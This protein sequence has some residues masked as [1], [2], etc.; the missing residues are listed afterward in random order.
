MNEV[1]RIAAEVRA[2]ERVVSIDL[3]VGD[4]VVAVLGPNGA[5]KTTL[6]RA[7]AGLAPVDVGTI[8]LDGTVV[9]NAT[10]FVPPE[11]RSVGMMF[12]DGRLFPFLD[13]R[14]NVAFALRSRGVAKREAR[15][16]AQV[17]LDQLG[18]AGRASARPAT[19]S[20]GEAQRVA[21]ARALVGQPRVLL[22]DEPLAALDAAARVAVRRDL[23]THL[24][25]APG[26]RILVTHDPVD[27]AAL[28]D[29]V[30]VLEGGRIVQEGSLAQVALHPRSDYAADL[31]GVNF[32]RGV[33]RNGTVTLDGGGSV[34]VADRSASGPV[35]VTVHPRSVALHG[36]DPGGSSRNRWAV[37]VEGIEDLGDRVRVRLAGP[38]DLVAEVTR[39]GADDLGLAPG[40]A[41]VATVKATEPAVTPA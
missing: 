22:L 17:W 32:L 25:A 3:S 6:L 20:G 23:R 10:T 24:A 26:A 9:D 38:P 27:A 31:A 28:A 35:T 12:Q 1:L 40:L 2:G 15:A 30:I 8:T 37:R 7:I 16:R 21:L 5:G 4:E 18:L 29:R 13:A 11:R 19:L 14:D 33:A 41:V 36:A 34:V 39:G